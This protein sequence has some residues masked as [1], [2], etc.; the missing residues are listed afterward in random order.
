MALDLTKHSQEILIA[1]TLKNH[2]ATTVLLS[3]I[4]VSDWCSDDFSNIWGIIKDHWVKY[5][6]V[7][8]RT[9]MME[10]VDSSV[11]PLL[12]K[13]YTISDLDSVA[14]LIDRAVSFIKA[15]RLQDLVRNVDS[16][17]ETNPELAEHTLR[18]GLAGMP[19]PLYNSSSLEDMLPDAIFNYDDNRLGLPTGLSVLDRAISG[20]MGLG[21]VFIVASPSGGGKSSLL[22]LMCTNVAMTVPCLYITLELTANRITRLLSSRIARV[23]Q[24]ELST[25]MSPENFIKLRQ[26]V[27]KMYPIEVSY[28]P[29]ETVTVAQVGGMIEYM[30]QVKGVN[31]Q[32]VFIDYADHM[33][34]NRVAKNSPKWEKIA[35]IYQELVDLGKV[36]NVT[37]FTASQLKNNEAIR[38]GVAESIESGDIA[39]SIEKINKTDVAIAWKPLEVYGGIAN[40]ILSFIKVREGEKP[41]TWRCSFNYDTL[42]FKFI[43][44]FQEA[45]ETGMIGSGN[46]GILN[47][48]T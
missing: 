42:S 22:A 17:L 27:S 19:V 34:T 18:K 29:S 9:T 47:R 23:K 11:V 16:T 5:K 28:Y 24:S 8:T 43:H 45:S 36:F 15:K 26:R 30:R 48:V 31:I 13:L 3:I 25:D 38:S 14:S 46:R 35:S 33:A 37:I 20:G 10:L 2:P 44:P 7:P 1:H 6:A 41:P 21:E 4:E 12:L 32:A 39:G 40:G